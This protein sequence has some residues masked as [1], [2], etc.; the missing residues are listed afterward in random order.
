MHVRRL[1]LLGAIVVLLLGGAIYLIFIRGGND[2]PLVEAGSRFG[3]EGGRGHGGTLMDT[4]AP[5]LGARV[6][7]VRGGSDPAPPQA[8]QLGSAPQDAVAGLFMV[9]FRGTDAT[10]SFVKRL[11]ARPYGGVL[12][13]GSNYTEPQQLSALTLALQTAARDAGHPAPIIA[14]PQEGG[15]FS[16]FRNLAPPAQVDVG[17]GRAPIR[18]SALAAGRQ[19]RA[20]GVGMNLAPNADI[21]VAGGPGQG[22]AFSDQV[23]KVAGAVKASVAAYRQSKVVAAVGPFPGDGGASQDPTEGPAAVGLSID[24]LR[25]SDMAPFAAIAGGPRAAPA[26]QMS[27]AIY[28]A[29]DGV[30]PATL[31]PDAVSELRDRLGFEGAIVSA[32]LVATTA[33]TGGSVG[34][35]AIDALKAGV[36]LLVVPGGRAQQDEAYRAVVAAVRSRAISSERVVEALRRI[37]A[38]RKLTRDA[39]TPL[40]PG[41]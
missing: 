4:L 21:A 8:D 1:A 30:T 18:D 35:A 10:S 36:D 2:A 14:A 5:V 16:A 25:R 34:E 29:F 32:D 31:L 41:A 37:A 22:R 6:S 20:L 27:N 28:A 33:T 24:E 3:G 12:L 39:R 38:V 23:P 11:G 40:R 17:N 9:G 13:T 15:E 19:L 26:I 7:S